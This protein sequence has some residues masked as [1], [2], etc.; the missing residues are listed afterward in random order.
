MATDFGNNYFT[1]EKMKDYNSQDFVHP[2]EPDAPNISQNVKSLNDI[3]HKMI[4]QINPNEFYIKEKSIWQVFLIVIL[5][6]G[7]FIAI[8]ILA[9]LYVP[10]EDKDEG[11]I[12]FTI[13]FLGI[14]CIFGIFGLFFVPNSF[15]FYL[16][17]DRIRIKTILN[18]RCLYKNTIL[19]RGEIQRFDIQFF[20]RNNSKSI[21]YINKF[22]QK[23]IVVILE[24]HGDE[25]SYFVDV[26]NKHLGIEMSNNYYPL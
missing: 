14:F 8:L 20:E 18:C 15:T 19:R 17:Q 16:E 9:L 5:T 2:K 7:G 6:T 4:K 13:C 10:D 12:I 26:L 1:S 11:L 25:A 23:K 3:P 22:G 21:F 24:F